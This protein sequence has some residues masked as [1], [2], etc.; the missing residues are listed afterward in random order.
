MIRRDQFTNRDEFVTLCQQ[1][2]QGRR[3]CVHGLSVNLVL[4]NDG[5]GLSSF[6]DSLRA[7]L[8]TRDVSS[9]W[10]PPTG[11]LHSVRTAFRSTLR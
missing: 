10:Y 3:H 9:R 8:K 5:A 11:G 4:K 1:L 6:Y 2:I 7:L